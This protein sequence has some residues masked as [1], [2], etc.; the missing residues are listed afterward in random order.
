MP[1]YYWTQ[2]LD[3]NLYWNNLFS[4]F[5][6]GVFGDFDARKRTSL[7]GHIISGS[8]RHGDLWRT[9]IQDKSNYCIKECIVYFWCLCDTRV[10]QS[11]VLSL[12]KCIIKMHAAVIFSSSHFLQKRTALIAALWHLC[13]DRMYSR[14]VYYLSRWVFVVNATIMQQVKHTDITLNTETERHLKSTRGQW[15]I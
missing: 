8:P 11:G 4:Y 13:N 10:P 6:K 15:W 3:A 2:N 7:V 9:K 1:S 12:I 5:W 14:S